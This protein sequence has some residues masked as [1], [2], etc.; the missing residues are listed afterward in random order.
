MMIIKCCW[1]DR[2]TYLHILK[3]LLSSG[4]L[5]HGDSD[6]TPQKI[7]DKY[8]SWPCVVV[9]L[10]TKELSGLKPEYGRDVIL[11]LEEF[12]SYFKTCTP[13]GNTIHVSDL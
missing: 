10:Q 2:E 3:V 12:M 11:G 9:N 8:S 4:Y 6:W 1:G 5:W 7:Y 13:N